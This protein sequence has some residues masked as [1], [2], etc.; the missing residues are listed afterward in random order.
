ME[1]VLQTSNVGMPL[2]LDSP[3]GHL[4][5]LGIRDVDGKHRRSPPFQASLT[6]PTWLLAIASLNGAR[7][8]RSM[9]ARP[10]SLSVLRRRCCGDS[11]AMTSR[12]SDAHGSPGSARHASYSRD[13]DVPADPIAEERPARGDL[14]APRRRHLEGAG[15]QYRVAEAYTLRSPLSTTSM[16]VLWIPG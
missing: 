14:G 3:S 6:V 15:D 4:D 10:V 13:G 7:D 2:S 12:A 5:D 16:Q 9:N 1:R 11:T 8:H